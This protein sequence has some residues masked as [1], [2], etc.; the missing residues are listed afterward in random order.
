[1]PYITRTPRRPGDAIVDAVLNQKGGTGKTTVA[2]NLAAVLGEN[3]Q[4]PAPGKDAPV[5]AAGIDPQGSM[6]QWAARVDHDALP[7]DYLATGGRPGMLA[8]LKGDPGVRRI[9]VDSPGF[10]DIEP[11]TE[12]SRDPLGHGAAADALRDLLAAAD[13]AIVPVNPEWM[14]L[15]PTEYTIE[16]VIR[17]LGIPFLVVVNKYD[18]RDGTDE[19]RKVWG[20]C[21]AHG[22]QRAPQPVRR[23]KIH[24]A[25]A[26]R[27]LVVTR[28]ATSGT[29]LRARE[30]FTNLA[31]ALNDVAL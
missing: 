22:Y 20:W 29:A 17:P 1:M 25:A 3:A 9:I 31:L 4:P 21:D 18:P 16:R 5:V 8:E 10:M 7:F 15:G 24:A 13:R 30:D 12:R 27:G 26:E 19:L 14:T 11:G 23:Y 2:V 6:E 28:Y